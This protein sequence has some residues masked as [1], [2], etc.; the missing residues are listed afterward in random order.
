MPLGRLAKV[1]DRPP[2][3]TIVRL[4]GPVTVCCGVDASVAVTVR[5]AVPG[6][7]GVPLIV[8]LLCVNPAGRVVGSIAAQ[9]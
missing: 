5:F 9:V 1:S 7:V 3:G 8:Q 2:A 6:V 4:S